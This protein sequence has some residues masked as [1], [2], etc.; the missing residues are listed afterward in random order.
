MK[1]LLLGLLISGISTA[2]GCAASGNGSSVAVN[3]TTGA[4]S[5][6]AI[7]LGFRS[8]LPCVK[9]NA[10]YALKADLFGNSGLQLADNAGSDVI[11]TGGEVASSG[12]EVVKD[13]VTSVDK[14]TEDLVKDGGYS[15]QV[16]ADISYIDK[17]ITSG[18]MSKED[19]AAKY[20]DMLSNESISQEQYEGLVS[21]LKPQ[22]SKSTTLA[23]ASPEVVQKVTEMSESYAAGKVSFEEVAAEYENLAS[24]GEIEKD[25]YIAL[26]TDLEEA[27]AAQKK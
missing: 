7:G 22:D 16:A 2:F 25:D 24:S 11:S 4:I 19:A 21:D 23:S 10:L 6:K 12:D 13:E 20:Q 8:T 27:Q 14:V 15:E 18:E 3:E 9:V 5:Q 17:A 1:V 26:M